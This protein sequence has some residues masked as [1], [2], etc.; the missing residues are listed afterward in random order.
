[1]RHGMDTF[2]RLIRLLLGAT[3]V[4]ERKLECGHELVV[5][6]ILVQPSCDGVLFQLCPVKAAKWLATLDAAI[7]RN[8]LDSGEAQKLSGRLMWAT[9][10]LFHRVGRAMIKSIFA[11]CRS[12]TGSVG[13]RLKR[14]LLWWQSVLRMRVAEMRAWNFDERRP[15]HLFV[16]AAS[17]P[18]RCA[19]VLFVDG[20]VL[21]TDGPPAPSLMHQLAA[22]ND[23]QITSLVLAFLCV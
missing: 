23:N 16:D 20:H 10:A 3:A 11:Q 19:A 2:A 4:S 7:E 9:Q 22:R 17:T 21:Y 1:M 8:H 15:C 18:A 6:G 12:S 5:L 13:P 14:A